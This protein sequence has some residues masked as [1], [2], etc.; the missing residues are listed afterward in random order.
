MKALNM[1]CS[2]KISSFHSAVFWYRYMN[3]KISILISQKCLLIHFL[4]VL[5]VSDSETLFTSEHV[6]LVKS[7]V[8]LIL[9]LDLVLIRCDIYFCLA[10][11]FFLTFSLQFY[12]SSSS[13]SAFKCLCCS[14]CF[15]L[16]NSSHF[17]TCASCQ[18]SCVQ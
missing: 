8:E 7:E 9:E 12:V 5:T 4:F 10:D 2:H 16:Q 18:K 3:E 11:N 13:L 15:W 6:I 17:Q 1:N 14:D